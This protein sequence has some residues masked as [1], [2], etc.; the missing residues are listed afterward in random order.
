MTHYRNYYVDK[1]LWIKDVIEN[2]KRIQIVSKPTDMGKSLNLSMLHTFI[3]TEQSSFKNDAF[4]GNLLIK[5]KE[6]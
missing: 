5:K 1:S 6:P 3:D 4:F 2:K